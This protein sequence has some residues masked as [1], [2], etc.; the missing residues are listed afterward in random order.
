M[1]LL[2][3]LPA[4]R[5]NAQNL[6]HRQAWFD[7]SLRIKPLK[8]FSV[9][10]EIGYR[11][12][13][14]IRLNQVYLRTY[15]SYQVHKN[16][17]LSVWAAQ[18]NSSKPA[19]QRAIEVRTSQFLTLYWP[20]IAGFRF[21]HRLGL[22]QRFFYLPG[23]EMSRQVHRS[24]VRIGLHT[25]GF[26]IF[27]SSK[28]LYA[29]ASFEVLHNINQGETSLWIDHD[30]IT[31]VLGFRMNEN[32]NIEANILLINLLDPISMEFE[33]EITAFRLRL[34]GNL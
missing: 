21:A 24:R 10:P 13:P 28:K 1:S 9:T 12:E 20:N 33:R 2:F 31:M 6:Q 3:G 22:D 27:G 15:L 25:P 23:Y 14:G 5:G 4:S 8:N 26:G 17:K 29:N 7:L 18:F 11:T 16:I 30:W 19:N 32:V 34:K